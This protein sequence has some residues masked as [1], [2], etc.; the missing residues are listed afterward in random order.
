MVS[1]AYQRP[2]MSLDTPPVR[3]PLQEAPEW[4]MSRARTEGARAPLPDA[5]L[6]AMRKLQDG[7]C[8]PHLNTSRLPPQLNSNAH[9]NIY[10]AC[11]R[12]V[13]L[14]N[15]METVPQHL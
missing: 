7:E 11:V 6:P 3:P 14:P 1:G 12:A 5:Q 4:T 8:L 10:Q 2:M 15:R 9:A 13:S